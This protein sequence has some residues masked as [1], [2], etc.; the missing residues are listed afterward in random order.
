MNLYVPYENSFCSEKV[1]VK[2]I[3]RLVSSILAVVLVFVFTVVWIQFDCEART[4]DWKQLYFQEIKAMLKYIEGFDIDDHWHDY[5][6]EKYPL[7]LDALVLT[8]LNFDGVPEL[9][10]FGNDNAPWGSMRVFSINEYGVEYV[11]GDVG[12]LPDPSDN[13]Y[14]FMPSDFN[15]IPYWRTSDSRLAYMLLSWHITGGGS[16][17]G[18]IYSISENTKLKNGFSENTKIAS[19]SGTLGDYDDIDFVSFNDKEVNRSE[20]NKLLSNMLTGYEAI[21][22]IPATLLMQDYGYWENNDNYAYSVKDDVLWAFLN[23]YSPPIIAL[24]N[25][26]VLSFDVPPQIVNDRTIVP[27][28]AIFE[29]M[30]ASVEWDQRTQTVTARKGDD[31]VILKIG[32]TSPTVNGRVVPID[33]PGFIVNGRTLA[34]LRF[35]AEA[36]GGTVTWDGAKRV[37]AITSGE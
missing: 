6:D 21:P 3:R 10:V 16:Y 8:D 5:L 11:F 28:R 18:D 32:D 17:D 22:Y 34:P 35:V 13:D 1:V 23:S 37:A 20:Y 31:I 33:Q 7:E 15:L 26:H 4:D 29:A 25:G 27:L 9:I 2:M 30:G 14:P 12:Y 36:F 19:F 24:L